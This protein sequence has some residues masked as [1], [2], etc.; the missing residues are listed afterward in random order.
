MRIADE[1]D[2]AVDLTSMRADDL[3]E[4]LEIERV[5]FSNPWR[6]R[7][8]A[9]ALE[10]DHGVAH[11]V[12]MDGRLVG[13]SVG[14]QKGGEF[15]L[16]DFAIQPGLQRRGYGR[17]LLERLTGEVSALGLEAITLEVRQSNQ[18][19]VHLYTKA[20]FQTVAIRRGYYRHPA[21]DALV[22]V[23]ALS[24]QLSDWVLRSAS[25]MTEIGE[26]D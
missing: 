10:A 18:A 23:K 21:E 6:E 24:G 17:A 3:S 12:R 11:V 4:V 5:S 7:D 14:F 13:Y 9:Y 19:A 15:H 2:V 20:G 25:R 26:S 22:M 8:F 1:L 16:A